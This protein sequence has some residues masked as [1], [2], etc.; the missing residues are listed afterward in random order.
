MIDLPP[1]VRQALL[2]LLMEAIKELIALMRH[3]IRSLT[4]CPEDALPAS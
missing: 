2:A 3:V 1:E 4:D